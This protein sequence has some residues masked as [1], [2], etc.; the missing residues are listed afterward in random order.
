MQMLT[1]GR[2][3]A[4]VGVSPKAIRLWERRGLIP[5]MPRSEAGYRLVAEDDLDH[6]RFIRQAQTLGL[7]LNEIRE[8]IWMQEAGCSPCE[9]V[10]QAVDTHLLRIERALDELQRLRAT[11]LAAKQAAEAQR[12]PATR[13]PII[14]AAGD[15]A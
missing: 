1:V 9:R 11:L 13:C 3:A 7:T 15:R 8:V 12:R 10:L 6:L 2:A 4:L 5:P 14:S